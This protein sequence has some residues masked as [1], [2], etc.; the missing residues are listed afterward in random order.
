MKV[1]VTGAAGF[2]GFS[3]SRALLERGDRVVGIDNV[4]DYYDVS[5]KEARLALLEQHDGFEFVRADVSDLAT[6]TEISD[7]HGPFPRVV[8]LAAQAGVRYSIENPMAYVQSNLVGHA[9]ILE[10][11]RATENFEHLTY[12]SS[13]SVYGGNAM[14]PF[15]VEDRVDRPISLYA[16]TKV[17]DELMSYTY[18]HLYDLP[19]TGLRFF[20]VYGPWGRPDMALYL[21]TDAILHDRPIRV[22]NFGEMQRDFTYIDDIVDGTIRALDRPPKMTNQSPAHRVFNLGNNRAEPLLK[23]IEIL[24]KTLGK[25]AER[26]LEPIQ[27]GD[28]PE[29]FADISSAARELGFAPKTGVE[30]GVAQFVDWYRTYHGI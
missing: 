2:I 28:V 21:F 9:S 13:S 25:Q 27:P 26:Q 12:A 18:S 10:L 15:S 6:L 1:L 11:C 4:N 29:T 5:L 23:V 30:E 17:A 24:E 3:V 8:H 19:Q 14:V 20:T 22:F 7:K 16:A